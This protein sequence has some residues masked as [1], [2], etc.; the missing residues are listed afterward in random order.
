MYIFIKT[1]TG[2]TV[3]LEVNQA[4]SIENVKRKIQYK[5]GISLE[6]QRLSFDGEQ[7]LDGKTLSD[8]NIQNKVVLRLIVLPPGV[9]QFSVEINDG[10]TV[11]FEAKPSTS[12]EKIKRAIEA[13][14]MTYSE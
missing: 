5:E 2:K 11:Y 12:I 7:L 6:R 13:F 1:S 10:S 9:L 3:T 14:H 8:C 4:E